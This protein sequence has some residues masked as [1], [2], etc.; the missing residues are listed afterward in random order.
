MILPAAP[1]G[2]TW[3]LLVPLTPTA[4]VQ[5]PMAEAQV[6]KATEPFDTQELRALR[7]AVKNA[8]RE[9]LARMARLRSVWQGQFLKELHAEVHDVA[10]KQALN[11]VISTALQRGYLDTSAYKFGAATGEDSKGRFALQVAIR[12][13]GDTSPFFRQTISN[14]MASNEAEAIWEAALKATTCASTWRA[15]EKKLKLRTLA[16]RL[17]KELAVAFSTNAGDLAQESLLATLGR[18]NLLQ[19]ADGQ[20]R[21]TI[22]RKSPRALVQVSPTIIPLV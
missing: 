18:H 6:Q 4:P 22:L 20:V 3:A 19:V 21:F 16:T 2:F 9:T 5:A 7:D 10:T 1:T 14:D 11:S 17:S 12:A 13:I 8:P 15:E